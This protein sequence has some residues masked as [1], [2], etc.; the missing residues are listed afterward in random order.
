MNANSRFGATTNERKSRIFINCCTRYSIDD[1]PYI[2]DILLEDGAT[3]N[4]AISAILVADGISDAKVRS[5]KPKRSSP[6]NNLKTLLV[7]HVLREGVRVCSKAI[8]HS[9]HQVKASDTPN[10]FENE[11]MRGEGRRN[12]LNTKILLYPAAGAV[13]FCSTFHALHTFSGMLFACRRSPRFPSCSSKA[14]TTP[15]TPR[16]PPTRLT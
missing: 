4:S 1:S 8:A 16:T 15:G 13:L 9:F 12:H 11:P 14:R 10:A 5:H 6:N 2:T 3:D 7:S